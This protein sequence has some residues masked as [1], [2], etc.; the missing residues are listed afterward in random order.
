MTTFIVTVAYVLIWRLCVL[1]CGLVAIILGYR[2]FM[3]GFAVHEG[4]LEAGVGKNSLKLINIAPGTFFALFGAVIIA[5]LI[6][7]TPA[8]I[9]IP[10]EALHAT[11]EVETGQGGLRVR[12]E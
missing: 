11:G 6:W 1:A 2:L 7:T 12:G 5:T 3:N 9:V 10:K 4:S 8:E